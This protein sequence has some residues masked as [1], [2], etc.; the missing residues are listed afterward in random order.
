MLT[1]T[2]DEVEVKPDEDG[3]YSLTEIEAVP[4]IRVT[5]KKPAVVPVTSPTTA[6]G[7]TAPSG[8]QNGSQN[9][10]KPSETLI[11]DGG[12]TPTG[13]TDTGTISHMM[14]VLL[15][16]CLITMIVFRKKKDL[17]RVD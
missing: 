1:V 15:V 5:L 12:S 13:D 10:T 14:L 7:A 9:S 6:N 11:D 17:D 3:V 4:I 2:V 16:T 8:A